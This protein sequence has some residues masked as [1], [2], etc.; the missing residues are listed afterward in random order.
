MKLFRIALAAAFL[1]GVSGV[2]PLLVE[3]AF[4][5]TAKAKVK[6]VSAKNRS[7]AACYARGIARGH[8]SAGTARW[9]TANGY[10]Q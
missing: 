2:M 6:K 3:P 4:A 9:C 7:Y 1:L 8:S 5:Q 10:T